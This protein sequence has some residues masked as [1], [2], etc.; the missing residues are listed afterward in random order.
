MMN[1]AKINRTLIR[2]ILIAWFGFFVTGILIQFVFPIP[3]LTLLIDRSYCPAEDWQK[4]SRTYEKLYR[5][6]EEKTLNLKP[7]I[8]F[9]SLG[10]DV[11]DSPPKPVT[12]Q[13][14]N[15]YGKT[16]LER[17]QKLQQSY[18]QA[19]LLSCH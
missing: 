18:P 17:R 14:M 10:E 2:L 8:L 4:I 1:A 13:S 19:Q 9:S 11:L 3:S 12:L 15:T 6:Y 7:V 5:S 16:D